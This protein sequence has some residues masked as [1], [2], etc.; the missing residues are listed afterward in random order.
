MGCHGVEDGL[1][2]RGKNVGYGLEA[3]RITVGEGAAAGVA[4]DAEEGG[5]GI[6]SGVAVAGVEDLAAK[7]S[8]V[9]RGAYAVGEGVASPHAA[10]IV[11]SRIPASNGAGFAAKWPRWIR[12]RTNFLTRAP[13]RNSRLRDDFGILYCNQSFSIRSLPQGEG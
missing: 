4:V 11:P 1:P 9:F 10:K 3:G 6:G 8:S 13:R 12:T 5:R 2:A 7:G